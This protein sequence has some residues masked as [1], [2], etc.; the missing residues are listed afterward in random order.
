M[1]TKAQKEVRAQDARNRA[2]RTL[3]QGLA[4]DVLAAVVLVVFTAVSKA[5][6]WSDF[7]WT[8]LAFTVFK[9]VMVS[10][11]SYLMRTVFA[12]KFPVT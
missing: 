4:F 6:A 3:L 11:L 5:E 12:S 9:S 10:G 8:L 7:E 2:W 1:V